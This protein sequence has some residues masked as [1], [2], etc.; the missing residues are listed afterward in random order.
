M[1]MNKLIFKIVIYYLYK[2]IIKNFSQNGAIQKNI[3]MI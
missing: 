2:E 3:A 1:N